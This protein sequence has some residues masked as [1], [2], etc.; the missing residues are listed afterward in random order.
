MVEGAIVDKA[1]QQDKHS[2]IRRQIWSGERL[3]P[4]CKEVIALNAKRCKHCGKVFSYVSSRLFLGI[5]ALVLIGLVVMI[6]L[7]SY[8]EPKKARNERAAIAVLRAVSQAQQVYKDRKGWY[9]TLEELIEAG[10][11]DRGLLRRVKERGLRSWCLQ[12][13]YRFDHWRQSGGLEWSMTAVPVEPDV[14]GSMSF[15]I[16]VSGV[17]HYNFCMNKDDKPANSRSRVLSR[18][19]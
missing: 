19:W 4:F 3:C 12:S 10:L 16:D 6:A 1:E 8:I 7:P 15:Y 18:Q 17:I 9:L 2:P 5:C 11:V 13:G 14:T